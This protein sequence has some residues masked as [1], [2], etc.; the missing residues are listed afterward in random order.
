VYALAQ[1]IG[2]SRPEFRTFA[3]PTLPT[4]PRLCGPSCSARGEKDDEEPILR[5][6]D[7]FGDGAPASAC[8]QPV[9]IGIRLDD[10]DRFHRVSR[11]RRDLAHEVAAQLVDQPLQVR[12]L[13]RVPAVEQLAQF[14]APGGDQALVAL[15]PRARQR[16]LPV[17]VHERLPAQLLE[18][19]RQLLSVDRQLRFELRLGDRHALAEACE[20][21]QLRRR[22]VDRGAGRRALVDLPPLLTAGE[23]GQRTFDPAVRVVVAGALEALAVIGRLRG[24]PQRHL[25]QQPRE[26]ERQE[27]QAGPG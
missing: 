4:R 22:Q 6:S 19:W 9:G 2:D 13:L 5:S 25:A 18:R 23:P 26:R 24:S 15:P 21:P 20:Q 10:R 3:I 7:R 12:M 16:D 17:G 14:V 11:G 1:R 27:R 8:G